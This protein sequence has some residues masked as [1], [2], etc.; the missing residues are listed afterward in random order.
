MH[1]DDI[2]VSRLRDGT[3][4][5]RFE[6]L[7][8]RIGTERSIRLALSALYALGWAPDIH[9]GLRTDS[10]TQVMATERDLR[11][12]QERLRANGIP[13]F[14]VVHRQAVLGPWQADPVT[15]SAPKAR[16]RQFVKESAP[17]PAPR[18]VHRSVRKAATPA[19]E[20]ADPV[21]DAV[22]FEDPAQNLTYQ[23]RHY[24]LMTVPISQREQWPLGEY[25][26]LPGFLL[27][28][29]EALTQIGRGQVI[30][31]IVDVV[32]GR[33]FESN[34]RKPR[35]KREG[36]GEEHR[37]IVYRASDGAQAWRANVQNGT[38]AARRIQWWRRHDGGI[39][40]ARLAVHDDVEMER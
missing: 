25:L 7:P 20:A 29:E 30:S 32:C 36:S 21:L 31:A 8:I 40:L 24:Y 28:V 17:T 12:A 4:E 3:V 16:Q 38:P 33:A 19:R 15:A 23:V 1:E 18:P 34:S 39:E 11:D 27:D 5:W 37:P 10:V 9:R 26:F 6:D 35:P 2:E 14:E 13:R 22:L